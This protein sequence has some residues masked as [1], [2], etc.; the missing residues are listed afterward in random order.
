LLAIADKVSKLGLAHST[1]F[2]ATDAEEN[3][4]YGAKAFTNNFQS[5]KTLLN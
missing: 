5:I 1:I 4:L 3:G 2:L